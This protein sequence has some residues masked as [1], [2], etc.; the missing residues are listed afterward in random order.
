MSS[1]MI[2]AHGGSPDV[3]TGR[4][5]S[6][7]LAGIL[8]DT[9]Q[10]SPQAAHMKGLAGLISKTTGIPQGKPVMEGVLTSTVPA[11]RRDTPELT[12][13][14]SIDKTASKL[15]VGGTYAGGMSGYGGVEHSKKSKKSK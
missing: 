7:V 3:A 11:S 6:L 8:Q 5:G 14:H 9:T 13:A 2:R 1:S 12:P 15:A 10:N 4:G